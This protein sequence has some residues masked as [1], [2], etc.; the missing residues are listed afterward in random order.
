MLCDFKLNR[1][2]EFALLLGGQNISEFCLKSFPF[3]I[4]RRKSE[5]YT[6]L[7]P[8]LCLALSLERSVY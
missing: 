7:M 1:L 2:C 6:N 8:N 4:Y 5:G 3:Q